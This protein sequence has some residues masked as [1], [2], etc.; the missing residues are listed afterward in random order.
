MPYGY[1]KLKAWTASI[2]RKHD[3][4]IK[5]IKRKAITH[6]SGGQKREALNILIVLLK[7][8]RLKKGIR[9]ILPEK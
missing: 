1:E 6:T 7:R 5:S 8:E 2:N 9:D 3:V 4:S